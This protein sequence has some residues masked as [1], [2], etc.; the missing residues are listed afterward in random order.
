[1]PWPQSIPATAAPESRHSHLSPWNLPVPFHLIRSKLSVTTACVHEHT[2]VCTLPSLHSCL[3]PLPP[4][5][6]DLSCLR[7]KISATA[8]VPLSFHRIPSLSSMTSQEPFLSEE[9]LSEITSHSMEYPTLACLADFQT[10]RCSIKQISLIHLFYIC[11]SNVPQMGFCL[12]LCHE[13]LQH[14]LAH[15][16]NSINTWQI[17]ES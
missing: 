5:Q 10:S 1:M 11:I 7:P 3:Q 12:I 9:S 16:G 4:V 2:S 14:Y 15:G 13:H 17:K 8:P 6:A